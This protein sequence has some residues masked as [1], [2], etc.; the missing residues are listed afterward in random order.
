MILKKDINEM[1]EKGL[2][3]IDKNGEMSLTE[4]G[5]IESILL[6]NIREIE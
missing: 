4:K 3:T 5:K 1:L 2:I 6:F